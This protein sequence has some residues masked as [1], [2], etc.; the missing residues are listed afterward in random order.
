LLAR[1]EPPVM[2]ATLAVVV[3]LYVFLLVAVSS[4]YIYINLIILQVN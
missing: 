1:S 4:Y 3:S 2:A